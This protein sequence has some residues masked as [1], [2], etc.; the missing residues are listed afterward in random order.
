[1]IQGARIRLG[2]P[3]AVCF[4]EA[5]VKR[6]KTVQEIWQLFGKVVVTA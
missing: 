3:V 2:R 4:E 1:M 5:V 6:K